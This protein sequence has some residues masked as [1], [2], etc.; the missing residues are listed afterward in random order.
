MVAIR[1]HNQSLGY[2]S[3]SLKWQ[4]QS[5]IPHRVTLIPQPVDLEPQSVTHASTNFDT[6]SF[7]ELIGPRAF[8]S[9][10]PIF[11]DSM[12]SDNTNERRIPK[13]ELCILSFH[14]I[15]Q[16]GH[17]YPI[18]LEIKDTRDTTRS[19]SYLDSHLEIYNEDLLRTKRDISIFPLWIFY[20]YVQHSSRPMYGVYISQLIR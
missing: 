7:F 1:Y 16:G 20:W 4:N 10:L 18:E 8:G 2:H 11:S 19:A 17:I 5:L 13:F 3:Q 6:V 12:V 14:W 15:I 9:M